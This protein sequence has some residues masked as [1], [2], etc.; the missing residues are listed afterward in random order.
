MNIIFTVSSLLPESGG[1]SRTSTQ[2]CSAL[3]PLGV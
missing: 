1:T 2:L 3:A